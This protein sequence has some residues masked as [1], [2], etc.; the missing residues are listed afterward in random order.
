MTR[1]AESYGNH[2]LGNEDFGCFPTDD[3]GFQ[4][5][6]NFGRMVE[7]KPSFDT[8]EIV[9]G[10]TIAAHVHLFYF[11]LLP[12]ILSYLNNIP[13][14]FDLFVSIPET[15]SYN[16]EELRE[17]LG[18]IEHIGTTTIK[19]TP[20]R[21]RDI[22][23]MLCSFKTELQ[24]YNF[25]LHIQ[26]KK[27]SQDNSLEE[28]RK[29]VFNHLLHSKEGVTYILQRLND[30]VGIIA[31]PD[32][33]FCYDA[34]GWTQNMK[35]AQE[36]IDRSK[37]DINLEAEVPTV[38]FPQGSMFWCK[39][40]YLEELFNMKWEYDD[41]P[42][43]PLPLDGTMVHALE[44]LFF[45]WGTAEKGKCC[46][47]YNNAD[48]MYLRARVEKEMLECH[49]G[50]STLEKE[51]RKLQADMADME[52]E[53]QADLADMEQVMQKERIEHKTYSEET[54]TRIKQQLG[55]I[56]HLRRKVRKYKRLTYALGTLATFIAAC[57]I[58]CMA[59]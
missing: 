18:K 37:L 50:K 28:W 38:K 52:Q 25:M 36:I 41:F 15:V 35:P 9:K 16:A 56:E 59:L 39:T 11:D 20:N 34:T 48:E 24:K 40:D 29:F 4:A 2:N 13:C 7:Q 42:E 53:L 22:A 12:E 58:L 26:T 8:T 3:R 27:S 51:K 14:T 23:P 57:S 33:I 31:P 21:G 1:Q 55:S 32:Y 44:R 6:F 30:D 49:S 19:R 47:I 5:R 43:E 46:I 54:S 17:A 45:L 10:K